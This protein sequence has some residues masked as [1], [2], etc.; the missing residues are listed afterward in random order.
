[1]KTKIGITRTVN[2]ERHELQVEPWKT[3]L[4][5]EKETKEA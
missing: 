5:G 4:L 1:M 2:G 3:L